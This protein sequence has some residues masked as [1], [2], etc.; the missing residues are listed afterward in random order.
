M[1][2]SSL[3]LIPPPNTPFTR[4]LNQYI[5]ATVPF[6]F[7]SSKKP[8]SFIPHITLTSNIPFSLHDTSPD[9]A[10]V[11]LDCLELP[12]PSQST[13]EEGEEQQKIHVELCALEAGEAFFKK[14]TLKAKKD[15]GLVKLA[16]ACRAQGAL[17]GDF[18]K[19]RTWGTHDYEPHLSLM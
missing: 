19:A 8:P 13:G 7:P 15:P 12:L 4:Q 14:L 1:P 10:Q 17:S 2:G 11:W 9:T 5:S 6:R 3:W 18:E 16:V